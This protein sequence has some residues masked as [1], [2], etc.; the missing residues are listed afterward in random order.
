M[1]PPVSEVDAE[2]AQRLPPP[3]CGASFGVE[4]RYG[5]LGERVD[6]GGGGWVRRRT[7]HSHPARTEA[8]KE[9]EWLYGWTEGGLGKYF[10]IDQSSQICF[11][12]KWA[13]GLIGAKK[14]NSM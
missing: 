4:P 8:G 6:R 10:Q 12:R 13:F 5:V 1:F 3:E 2:H 9:K 14:R 7:G 11:D